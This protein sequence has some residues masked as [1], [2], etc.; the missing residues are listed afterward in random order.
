VG[1]WST[2]TQSEGIIPMKR[3]GLT[4]RERQL[5]RDRWDAM[6]GREEADKRGADAAAEKRRSKLHVVKGGA[7]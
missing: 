4:E 1:I 3:Q 2:K 5:G 7:K 6:V